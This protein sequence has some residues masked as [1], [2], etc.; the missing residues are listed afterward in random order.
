M[1]LVNYGNFHFATEEKYFDEFNYEDTEEH[2]K[3][4]QEFRDKLE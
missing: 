3:R 4:H 1:Q 2:K